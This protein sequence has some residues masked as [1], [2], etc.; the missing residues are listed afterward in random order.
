M[1]SQVNALVAAA[2]TDDRL[3]A[4]AAARPGHAPLDAAPA[5]ATP[6]VGS[7]DRQSAGRASKAPWSL[8][9]LRILS[10]TNTFWRS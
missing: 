9:R 6:P 7:T 2:R 8:L 10:F 5:G 1:N 4:A 3:R